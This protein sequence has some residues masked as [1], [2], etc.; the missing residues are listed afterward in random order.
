MCTAQRI[1]VLRIYLSCI[2]F[3]PKYGAGMVSYWPKSSELRYRYSGNDSW[4]M[5]EH[6]LTPGHDATRTIPYNV[7]TVCNSQKEDD[8]QVAWSAC[9]LHW[10]RKAMQ[11]PSS[12]KTWQMQRRLHWLKRQAW[13]KTYLRWL[14]R[15]AWHPVPLTIT[16]TEVILLASM[17]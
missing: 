4:Y 8:K 1:L 17:P 5:I 14:P 9:R 12:A 7:S 15:Y 6:I 11:S 10:Q 3:V 16:A 13:R 2:Y